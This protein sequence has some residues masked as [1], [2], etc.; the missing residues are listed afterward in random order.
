MTLN[1]TAEQTKYRVW[2]YPIRET[3]INKNR[4]MLIKK[5]ARGFCL[6][7]R[8]YIF[9]YIFNPYSIGGW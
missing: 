4:K 8:T 1:S 5:Y 3:L 6:Y 7:Q 2:D 9:S